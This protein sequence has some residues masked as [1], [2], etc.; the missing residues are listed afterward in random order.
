MR[1]SKTLVLLAAVLV[2]S[3]TG[4][5]MMANGSAAAP[6]DDSPQTII[7][8]VLPGSSASVV[9]VT[10]TSMPRHKTRPATGTDAVNLNITLPGTATPPSGSATAQQFAYANLSWRADLGTAAIGVTKTQLLSYKIT[11]AD[12]TVPGAAF[13]YFTNLIR[14][15]PGPSTPEDPS[16]DTLAS[17]SAVA[18]AKASVAALTAA[19]PAGAI[20]NSTVTV[21]PITSDASQYALS[22]AVDLSDPALLNGHIGDLLQGLGTG[23]VAGADVMIEGLEITVSSAGQPLAGSW[24]AIR[25]GI[26]TVAFD[27]SIDQSSFSS[28]TVDFPNLTGLGGPAVGGVLGAP[29]PSRQTSTGHP[30]AGSIPGSAPAGSHPGAGSTPQSASNG[31]TVTTTRTQAAPSRGHIRTDANA[32]KGSPTWPITIS[33]IAIMLLVSAIVLTW[34]RRHQH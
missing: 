13:N 32:H 10:V 31:G 16:I 15:Q 27:P 3:G 12:G 7:A 18:Q 8:R 19:L 9:P 30:G 25:S 34:R 33:I 24:Q 6:K 20:T 22:I 29:A 2:A 26:G 14:L 1:T 4:V 17:S 23:L 21:V 28:S 5:V 11:Y